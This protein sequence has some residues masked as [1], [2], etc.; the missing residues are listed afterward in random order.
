MIFLS[1]CVIQKPMNN[2]QIIIL[3]PKKVTCDAEI[4]QKECYQVKWTEDQDDWEYIYNEIEGFTYEPGYVYKLFVSKKVI[5]N[6]PTDASSLQFSLIRVLEKEAVCKNPVTKAEVLKLL[7]Q[8]D[9]LLFPKGVSK[10]EIAKTPS[11]QPKATFDFTNC[12][13]TVSSSS[14]EPVTYDGNCA[15]TNGCTPEIRLTVKVNAK[16]LAIIDQKK[17]RILHPNYE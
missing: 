12:I 3:G 7:K 8:K 9:L 10:S 6:P 14:Y 2:K 16:T 17:K 11:Y 1:S 13:W 15:N 4:M 5:D